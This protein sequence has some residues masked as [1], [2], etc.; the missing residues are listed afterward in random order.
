[1]CRKRAGLCFT[2]TSLWLGTALLAI[3]IAEHLCLEHLEGEAR[4]NF[5][6]STHVSFSIASSMLTRTTRIIC[7]AR[8]QRPIFIWP[9][10]DE[11]TLLLSGKNHASGELDYIQAFAATVLENPLAVTFCSGT[12]PLTHHHLTVIQAPLLT[13]PTP[14]RPLHPQP[15]LQTITLFCPILGSI[16]PSASLHRTYCPRAIAR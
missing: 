9:A 4:L 12:G 8:K 10:A 14:R 3:S 5:A 16:Q 15:F 1:M 2:A 13:K 6:L 7:H 11:D